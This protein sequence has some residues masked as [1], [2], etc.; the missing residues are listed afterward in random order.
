MRWVVGGECGVRWKMNLLGWGSSGRTATHM[1]N[2]LK[3]LSVDFVIKRI[4]VKT[5]LVELDAVH[6]VLCKPH[7]H[8]IVVL[9]MLLVKRGL[10]PV[11]TVE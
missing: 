6:D 8:L 2:S 5:R 3:R 9:R 4:A 1:L 10:P 7:G 11:L